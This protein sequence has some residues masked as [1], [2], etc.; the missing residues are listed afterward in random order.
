MIPVGPEFARVFGAALQAG[1]PPIGPATVRAALRLI[2]SGMLD[3]GSVGELAAAL[4][5]GERHLRRLFARY[6]GRSPLNVAQ[7]RRLREARRLV[8]ATDRSMAEIALAAGYNSV[9]R[10]NAAFRDYYGCSPRVLRRRRGDQPPYALV[11]PST[12][13]TPP[14]SQT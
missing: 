2:E 3:Q 9:R 11:L 7:E 12:R 6:V 5:I 8:W 4:G 14:V 1:A 13:R 10:F